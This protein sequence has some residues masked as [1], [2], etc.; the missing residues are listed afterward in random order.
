MDP[1]SRSNDAPIEYCGDLN[2]FFRETVESVCQRRSYV[3]TSAAEVYIVGL[4]ADH[5]HAAPV[6]QADS[7]IP[8]T[9]AL[10][11]ALNAVGNERFERLRRLGDGVLYNAGFFAEYLD[12]RGIEQSYIEEL[13]ARAYATAGRMLV[14]DRAEQNDVFDELAN[15]FHM[16]VALIHDVA[17]TLRVGAA[18]SQRALVELYESWLRSGSESLAAAL[19][20]R[21]LVPL[22]GSGGLQ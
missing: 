14:V 13:G 5:A 20:T 15:R 1:R 21:G 12:R 7:D 2:Q 22:R 17:E 16:F 6:N 8:L 4:L 18:R 9:L 10:A 3:A 19:A 11:K